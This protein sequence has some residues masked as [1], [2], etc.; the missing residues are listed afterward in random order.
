[1]NS[2]LKKPCKSGY[3]YWDH[4]SGVNVQVD[5]HGSFSFS[6]SGNHSGVKHDATAFVGCSQNQICCG[7]FGPVGGTDDYCNPDCTAKN[8]GTVKK[9]TY[10]WFWVRTSLPKRVWHRCMEYKVKNENGDMVSY[11]LLDGN[12]TPEKGGCPKDDVLLNEG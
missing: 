3:A 9:D 2:C 6:V 11:K 4:P 7:C 1:M 8:G 12:T 5:F 10:T